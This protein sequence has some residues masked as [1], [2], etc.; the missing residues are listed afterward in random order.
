M[1]VL[2]RIACSQIAAKSR[3]ISLLSWIFACK[4]QQKP[5]EAVSSEP[6]REDTP[7][8]LVA[9]ANQHII[10]SYQFCATL[11]LQTPLRVLVR[12]REFHSRL[13][14]PPPVI[15]RTA[16]EGVWL[17]K[18]KTLRELGFNVRDMPPGTMA[19]EIGQIPVDGG[20]YLKFLIAVREV[21]ERS[22]SVEDRRSGVALVLRDP[23]WQE[24]VGL[25][26]GEDA[27]LDR[28]F[29]PFLSTIP[30]MSAKVASALRASGHATP[31][32][33]D[34]ASDKELLSLAGVGP[35]ML[36]AVRSAVEAAADPDSEFVDRV[37]V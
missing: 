18:P 17:P 6:E 36:K 3:N 37:S 2:A 11:Q 35:S 1:L 14:T 7:Y 23:K 9:R 5:T 15:A 22:G 16:A 12:H 32:S 29:P 26:G 28:L 34:R 33:I 20:D 25:S 24:I 31:A 4:S 30:R 21:A 27:V 19:S 8:A 13:D 10:A